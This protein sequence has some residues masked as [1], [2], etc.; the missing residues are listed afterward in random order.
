MTPTY[1]LN[2]VQKHADNFKMLFLVT[3]PAQEN[4]L[5]IT[6]LKISGI[7]FLEYR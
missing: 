1:K 2:I 3:G 5:L 6:G 7:I 4:P